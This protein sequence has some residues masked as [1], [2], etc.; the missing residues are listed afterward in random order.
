MSF[1]TPQ[2]FA[3]I[4]AG[5]WLG[6]A[7]AD[8]TLA[9]VS[10]D[11]RAI[12]A[13]QVFVALA[14]ERFDAHDFLKDAIANDAALLIVSR[15]DKAIAAIG[16]NGPPTL[17]VDDTV[18]A[19]QRLATAY[20]DV[21]AAAEC[22]VIAVGGSNGKTTT[23]N[24]IHHLLSAKLKGTQSP[25]SFNNHIGVPLTL[26][27]ARE[28]DDFVVVEIGTNHPG[29]M[30]ALA[31]IVRP[32][33][34]AITS[35]GR[36]HMEFFKT[37]DGVAAEEGS[38]LRFVQPNGLAMI[39]CDATQ[40]E[41]LEKY[42][43][44]LSPD[45]QRYHFGLHDLHKTAIQPT[46]TGY[47]FADHNGVIFHVPLLG[48][49][50][51]NNACA[52]ICVARWLKF[53][54]ATIRDALATATGMPMRMQL[55]TLAD[56]PP[57]TAVINDAYNANPDSMLAAIEQWLDYPLEEAGHRR[58]VAIIGD[59]LELGDVA[60]AEHRGI[61][62][63]LAER[64]NA[65]GGDRPTHIIVIGR[66][67]VFYAESLSRSWKPEHLSI[68]PAWSDDVPAQVAALIKPGDLVLLKASRGMGLER[69]I[70]AMSA[71]LGVESTAQSPKH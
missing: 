63:S 8:L 33:V 64:L 58:R 7:P 49:H 60:P 19:M 2:S 70:P 16:D 41:L 68:F 57:R 35:V 36:E 69:L 13:G 50:N 12:K 34:A 25:K 62:Q 1:W 46:A 71:K 53:D 30:A 23:R 32:D 37:L 42:L 10:T 59:M 22:K 17:L 52:A 9:G 47:A 61:G 39:P 55:I 14:G 43:Q 56:K 67:A 3:S 45:I 40:V 24:L 44:A 21:L 27:A 5:R 28:S 26:L 38:L 11:T 48:R 20:R 18:A 31:E 29:E 54:D 4:T 15:M 6:A 65:L 66:L 51:V